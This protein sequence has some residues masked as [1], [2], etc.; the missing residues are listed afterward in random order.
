MDGSDRETIPESLQWRLLALFARSGAQER[1]EAAKPLHQF[2]E[3]RAIFLA[4][5]REGQSQSTSGLYV[6]YNRF[7][8]DLSFFHKKVKVGLLT[9]SPCVPCVDKQSAR[10]EIENSR[11]IV[12]SGRAPVDINVSGRLDPRTES[13]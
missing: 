13:S 2:G 6:A 4:H 1:A 7:R 3:A 8:S 11:G 12:R 9:Y 10:A 5:C